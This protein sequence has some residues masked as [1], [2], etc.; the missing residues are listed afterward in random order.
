MG[1]VEIQLPSC[2]PLSY[3]PGTARETRE[4]QTDRQEASR[5]G[6]QSSNSTQSAAGVPLGFAVAVEINGAA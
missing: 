6:Q 2:S 3:S 1:G 5:A 4:R